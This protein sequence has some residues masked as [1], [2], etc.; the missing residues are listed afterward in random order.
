MNKGMSFPFRIGTRG[1]I[2][3][4]EN[5]IYEN[6]LTNESM[7]Q[8]IK[9]SVG[10][11]RMEVQFGSTLK[12]LLFESKNP[13]MDNIVINAL[14]ED[15]KRWEPRSEVKNIAINRKDDIILIEVVYRDKKTDKIETATYYIDEEEF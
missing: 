13:S 3:M 1:R 8:I 10:E 2:V 7:E 4:S 6:T 9:T 5:S 12:N 14:E 15:L 11:R